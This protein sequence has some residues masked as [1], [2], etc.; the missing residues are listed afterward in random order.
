MS[1]R[2]WQEGPGYD[3][4][5]SSEQIVMAAIDSIHE[6]PARRGPPIGPARTSGLPWTS[7][8]SKTTWANLTLK[9]TI[10]PKSSNN[11]FRQAQPGLRN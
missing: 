11:R 7:V 8:T 1:F 4:N 5:L 3:R 6:N 2:Y 10:M 9:T